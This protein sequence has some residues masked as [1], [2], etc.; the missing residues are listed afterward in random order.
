MNRLSMLDR[1]LARTDPWD[2]V[3][4]GGGATGLGIAV[5]AAQRGY[6]TLLLEQFDFGKGT[7]SRSTKLVHGGVRYLAQ[8]NIKLVTEALYERSLM[9]ANAPHVARRLA[10]LVP[11]FK[12]W[13]KPYYGLGL[14]IYDALAGRHG[15]GRSRFVSSSQAIE[16]I[17]TLERDHLRGGIHYFDGQ[18]DDTRF[19]VHLARTAADLGACLINYAPVV[20]LMKTGDRVTGVTFRDGEVGTEYSPRARVVIN[21]TGVFADGIRQLDDERLPAM[22]RPSQG[23]HLVLDRS[24]LPGQTALMVPKTDDGRVLFIIPWHDRVIVGTTDTPVDQVSFEPRALPEE[25]DFVMT[26]ARRYLARDPV[27]SDVRSLFAG[28]RPLVRSTGAGKTSSLSRDHTLLIDRSGLITVTGGKWTTY[29]RMAQDAIG[30]AITVGGLPPRACQTPNLRL[31]GAVDR[32]PDDID[33]LA[34]GS[35]WPL[36]DSLCQTTTRGADLLVPGLPYRRGEVLWQAR[37][38]MARTVEDVLARRTRCLFLD[39]VGSVG[40]APTVAE[41]LAKELGKDDRWEKEQV[42]QYASLAAGYLLPR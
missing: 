2:I 7:S 13:E 5:D 1:V 30:R 26:H 6:D 27:E 36:V 9:L 19:L 16:M 41:I 28:Q 40:A 22:L 42:Q 25:F 14:K 21:A 3:V 38:E 32:S 34:Y 35:E 4:I 39:A 12:W 20:G 18:F 33:F 23:I 15:L 8:G 29:R 37:H 31:H 24:F 10:F 17:P 11:G